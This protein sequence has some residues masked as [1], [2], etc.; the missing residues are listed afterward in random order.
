MWLYLGI[1]SALFLGFYEVGRKHAVHDNAAFPVLWMST[2]AGTVLVVPV[3][4]LSAIK[5]GMMQAVSLY[6]PKLPM[7]VHILILIKVMLVGTS[8][9]LEMF[10]L[11]HLPISIYLPI[12][13][14]SPFWTLLGAIFIFHEAP[15]SMQWVGLVL[16]LGSY[17]AFTVL[18][19]KEGIS[20]KNNRWVYSVIVATIFGAT[21]GLYDKY[22]IQ[23]LGITPIVILSWFFVYISI[24]YTVI[25]F[26]MYRKKMLT[27]MHFEWRWS[28]PLIGI[29]L[30]LSDFMY[31]KAINVE[32]ALISL[33]MAVRRLNSIVSFLIGGAMFKEQNM[34]LKFFALAGVIAGVFFLLFS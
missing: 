4:I 2:L 6:V 18:G 10:A 23:K 29:F 27:S 21:C 25:M 1:I 30:T 33:V 32:G 12:R 24:V 26:V 17:Y 14:T 9:T 8:W 20:F 16:I 13:A 34:R 7:S 11:K 19:N 28:I 31:F 22:M 15:S 3:M 5:P